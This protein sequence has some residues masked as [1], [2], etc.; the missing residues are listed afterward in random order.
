MKT[1]ERFDHVITPAQWW[2]IIQHYIETPRTVLEIKK[3]QKIPTWPHKHKPLV[4]MKTDVCLWCWDSGC[5]PASRPELAC[6]QIRTALSRSILSHRNYTA[7]MLSSQKLHTT[8]TSA[9]GIIQVMLVT[10]ATKT[11]RE[12]WPFLKS[13][14]SPSFVFSD[15]KCCFC[16]QEIEYVWIRMSRDPGFQI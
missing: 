10:R 13:A 8:L 12:N 5:S 11:K 6:V 9:S 7:C 15:L 2:Y 16:E 1:P 14:F 3:W 4:G